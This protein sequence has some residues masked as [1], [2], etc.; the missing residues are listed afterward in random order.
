MALLPKSPPL[1]PLHLGGSFFPSSALLSPRH[2]SPSLWGARF[3]PVTLR[4][5]E[6][7]VASSPYGRSAS[8]KGTHPDSVCTEEKGKSCLISHSG[9]LPALQIDGHCGQGDALVWE[10]AG[11][12][13]QCEPQ[14]KTCSPC[15][16]LLGSLCTQLCVDVFC[17]QVQPAQAL[18]V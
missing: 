1:L 9:W 10:L 2:V 8:R 11:S 7:L 14:E 17:W 4:G 3:S 18:P 6:G 16:S 5:N 13:T 15:S 12:E